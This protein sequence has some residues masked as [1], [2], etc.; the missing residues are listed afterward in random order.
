MTFIAT[1]KE[2]TQTITIENKELGKLKDKKVV[3][4]NSRIQFKLFERT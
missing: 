3:I 2:K 1:D 4:R